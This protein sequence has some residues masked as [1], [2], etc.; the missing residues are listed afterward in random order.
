MV[1]PVTRIR[2]LVAIAIAVAPLLLSGCVLETIL[3]D[4]VNEDP[5]AVIE[6]SPDRKSV[7]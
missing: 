1:M 6:A 4:I 2:T 3:G 5:H 7:V